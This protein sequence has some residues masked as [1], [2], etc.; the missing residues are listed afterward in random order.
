MGKVATLFDGFKNF[1][2]Q[3][4][5]DRD[6]SSHGAYT[7]S[8][9][10]DQEWDTIYRVSWMA[11]KTVDI[12]AEDATRKWREWRGDAEDVKK[13]QEGERDLGVQG[14]VQMA[15]KKARCFGGA[16]IYLGIPGHDPMEELDPDRLRLGELK[17]L[18]VLTRDVLQAGPL[19]YDPFSEHYGTPSYYQI[20]PR[21]GG[22]SSM[23]KIHPS[24][25]VAFRGNDVLNPEM[26]AGPYQGWGDSVLLAA[27]DAIR[28]A[29]ATAANITAL[30]H[31]AKCDVLQI[32]N[33]AEIMAD[34]DARSLLTQ[35]V[36]LASQLKG[37]NGMLVLDTEEEYVNRTY[38]FSGLPEVNRQA[39]LAVSGAAD[40]PVTRFLGQ[41]PAGLASTGE[42]DLRNYYD[43]VAAH[44][45]LELDSAMRVLNR[46][47]IRSALGA[48]PDGLH[49]KWASLWQTTD[50]ERASISEKVVNSVEKLA[51]T[52]LFPDEALAN[53][54]RA[55]LAEH[56]LFPEI[57]E[58]E[59]REEEE[60][61]KTAA[62]N[63]AQNQPEPEDTPEDPEDV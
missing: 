50:E 1:V 24:R 62:L 17:Y 25:V 63:L 60:L 14:K 52:Q 10:T 16:G 61:M 22:E 38:N 33:L 21:G 40:I 18:V 7:L 23:L 27:H 35:R 6:K 36:Q 54:A 43:S 8:L 20:S 37:N 59:F 41:T 9:L 30:V 45:T 26:D 53:S 42:S 55:A 48:N 29:D 46:A 2:A 3:L 58:M 39:L 31:E 28:N 34:P 47:I 4:G 49:H 32:P 57:E 11:R 15:L 19:Q 56:S 44:Q 51:G 12:P 5:T 13:V